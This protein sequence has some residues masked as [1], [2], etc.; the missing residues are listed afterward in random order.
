MD[1]PLLR[2]PF[3]LTAQLLIKLHPHFMLF[4]IILSLGCCYSSRIFLFF[5]PLLSSSLLSGLLCFFSPFPGFFTGFGLQLL[6]GC[7]FMG[8]EELRP[9]D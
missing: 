1:A 9:P 4:F 3:L 7:Q 6:P 5:P 2:M 8:I